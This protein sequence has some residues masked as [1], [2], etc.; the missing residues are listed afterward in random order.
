MLATALFVLVPAG[1]WL[2]F[3]MRAFPHAEEAGWKAMVPGSLLVGV[4][5]QLLHLFT[6]LWISRQVDSKSGT[7]GASRG[8]WSQRFWVRPS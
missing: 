3:S 5:T 4:G 1:L 7:Y 6:V 2:F 8:S